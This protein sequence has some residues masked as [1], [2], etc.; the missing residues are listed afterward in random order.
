LPRSH[1]IQSER[2]S[3]KGEAIASGGFADVH[4]AELDGKKVCIKVLRSYIQDTGGVTK[5]VRSFSSFIP[6][7][8]EVSG[9]R[10][11]ERS[12][13][14]RGYN[15]PTSSLSLEFPQTYHRSRSFVNGWK[16]TGLLNM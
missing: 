6:T 16:T 5:K 12:W 7:T 9:R 13:C 4:E 10:F 2:I 11:T 15:I 8:A 1:F 14:G 3:N